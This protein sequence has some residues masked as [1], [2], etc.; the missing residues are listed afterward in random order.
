M[1]KCPN[2]ENTYD[3]N[4]KFCQKDGTPLVVVAE[5]KPEED[6]FKTTVGKKE[7][8]PVA[9]EE[10]AT[11]PEP[12]PEID[13]YATMVAGA[14][15]PAPKEEDV[16]EVPDKPDDP[17][18]TMVVSGQTAGK[19]EIDVPKEEPAS[20]GDEPEPPVSVQAEE[21]AAAEPASAAPATP[22]A[23]VA[24]SAAEA[25]TPVVEPPKEDTPAKPIPSPFEESMPPGFEAPKTPPFETPES[26]VEP[27][28]AAEEPQP[29]AS[30]VSEALPTDFADVEEADIEPAVPESS[31]PAPVGSPAAEPT[32]DSTPAADAGEEGA[33]QTLSI[34]AL[35]LGILSIICCTWL[36]PGVIAIIVGFIARNK[37][38]NEPEKYAGG[39]YATIGMVLGGIS[40]VLGIVVGVVL[41]LSGGL[42]QFL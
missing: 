27:V 36:I 28:A 6:P 24:D 26:P 21:P 8:I 13:P 38:I 19:I 16:L 11:E 14:K 5:D 3:D 10:K 35:V 42:G 15:M 20:G 41:F 37:A 39:N 23:E 9:P 25:E 33:S 18:A 4:L 17:M 32:D 40:I 31:M 12:E 22:E 2:C 29:A 1:K 30:D 7:D 34:V